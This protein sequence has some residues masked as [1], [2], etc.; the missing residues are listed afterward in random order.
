MFKGFKCLIIDVLLITLIAYVAVVPTVIKAQPANH[1]F[2]TIG[3][4]NADEGMDI[5]TGPDG[6][7]YV[8]GYTYSYS[9]GYNDVLVA[10]LDNNGGL[11]WFK[12]TRRE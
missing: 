6:Y 9:V 7:I 2:E 5:I 11:E 10:K 12:T 8:A 1:W 4:S 3:G